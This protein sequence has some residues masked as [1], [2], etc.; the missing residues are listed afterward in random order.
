VLKLPTYEMRELYERNIPF[1]PPL[2]VI[3]LAVIINTD[4]KDPSPQKGR[5]N[6]L[7]FDINRI[8][9]YLGQAQFGIKERYNNFFGLDQTNI[10]AVN[11]AFF[12]QESHNQFLLRTNIHP[13]NLAERLAARI[14]AS[15]TLSGLFS[16]E[17]VVPETIPQLLSRLLELPISKE[18]EGAIPFTYYRDVML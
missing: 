7:E 2:R 13:G 18:A 3:D 11:Q 9:L 8:G 1:Q 6:V 15:Y 17:I 14:K 4:R 10:T 16:A 12:E 5:F